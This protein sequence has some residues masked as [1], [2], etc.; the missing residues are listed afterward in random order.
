VLEIHA[1]QTQDAV[2]LAVVMNVAAL[3]DALEIQ[4]KDVCAVNQQLFVPI[5]HV[6]EMQHAAP[7]AKTSQ[8]ATVHHF[9]QTE[10]HITNVHNSETLLTVDKMDV[11]RV[12][13]FARALNTYANK[14]KN[15]PVI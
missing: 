3:R 4:T 5:M 6:D 13:V 7:L 11:L 1:V 14:T 10:I 15:V 8:N 9:I 12:N 2:M